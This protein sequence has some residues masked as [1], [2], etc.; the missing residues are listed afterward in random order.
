MKHFQRCSI[1]SFDPD[2]QLLGV[3][4][5][6]WW[7]QQKET[8]GK[9]S[10]DTPRYHCE[11]TSKIFDLELGSVAQQSV[12]FPSSAAEEISASIHCFNCHLLFTTGLS[13]CK[14]W[15]VNIWRS[16]PDTD[17]R[18]YGIVFSY[19]LRICCNIT[20]DVNES[21]DRCWWVCQHRGIR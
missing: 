1:S 16:P 7:S 5:C 13:S 4:H 10:I 21:G 2:S 20:I 14:I 6:G 8:L 3:F 17:K 18:I 15:L 9:R 11:A 19:N 12:S